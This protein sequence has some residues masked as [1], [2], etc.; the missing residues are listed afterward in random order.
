MAQVT[1]PG[2]NTLGRSVP[3]DESELVGYVDV[4][5][6]WGRW[7]ADDKLGTLNLIDDNKRRQA[8]ALVRGGLAVSLARDIDPADPDP[9]G[10]G[11]T[12]Q[13]FMQFMPIGSPDSACVA[14]RDY[15]GLVAHG[16]HTHLDALS[17][18]SWHGRSYNGA[19]AADTTT[20]NG[21]QAL[22]A[23]H[24][25][26]GFL[27]RG[28]LLDIPALHSVPWLPPGTVVGPDEIDAALERQG[29]DVGPGDALALYTGNF[30]RIATEGLDPLSRSPGWSP[31]AL[32]WLHE[33]D[34]ALIL[35]DNINDVMAP[36]YR[37]PELKYPIHIVSLVAMGM[38]MVDNA[39]LTELAGACRAAG[40]Y[41]FM[42]TM[43]PWR[44]VGTTSSPVN[45]IAIL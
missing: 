33:H 38:W 34:V 35:A 10:R 32:P 3:P 28:V 44:V 2:G 37:S 21:A 18:I 12:V 31:A 23:H 15:V 43:Q 30:D 45:P 41:E 20:L 26:T 40:R 36:V 29:V 9:L 42:F 39:A 22:S 4:L 25:V 5:S 13:R 11:T 7:G 6:N 27:T 1:A 24:A 19:A 8:A 14:Y 16:S 17:H